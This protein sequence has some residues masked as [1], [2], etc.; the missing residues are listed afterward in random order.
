MKTKKAVKKLNKVEALL[1][2]IIDQYDAGDHA[3]LR[4][5]LTSAK[6]SV[7]LAQKT[8]NNAAEAKTARK[9]A[10]KADAAKNGKATRGG[11]KIRVAAAG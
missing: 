2:S 6:Q 7:R 4:E 8:V 1:S 3:R 10:A 11:R 5:A 9:P